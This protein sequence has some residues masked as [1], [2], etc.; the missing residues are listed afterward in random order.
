MKVA[1]IRAMKESGVRRL[2]C[3]GASGY[4]KNPEDPFFIRV[5]V[6][7]VLQSTF[8]MVC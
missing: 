7:S 8:A 6:K 3:I 1:V 5:L 4:V 2:V